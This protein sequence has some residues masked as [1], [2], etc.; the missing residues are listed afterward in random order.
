M[1]RVAVAEEEE[2]EKKRKK[3]EAV[4]E[5]A[6]RTRWYQW[7]T[8]CREGLANRLPEGQA[9]GSKTALASQHKY[10]YFFSTPPPFFLNFFSFSLP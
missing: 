8:S 4:G 3:K 1:R 10:K 6:A 2:E 9:P 7:R 5:T